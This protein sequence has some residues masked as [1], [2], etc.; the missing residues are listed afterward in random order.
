MTKTAAKAI[1]SAKILRGSR[2]AVDVL[3]ALALIGVLAPQDRPG[4]AE[5]FTS[6][7]ERDQRPNVRVEVQAPLAWW[8]TGLGDHGIRVEV[9]EQLFGSLDVPYVDLD[10]QRPAPVPAA[11]HTVD[12]GLSARVRALGP[13]PPKVAASVGDGPAAP[14]DVWA[15]RREPGRWVTVY[16]HEIR[17]RERPYAHTEFLTGEHEEMPSAAEITL[18]VQP[19]ADGRAPT[20]VHS[21]EKTSWVRRIAQGLDEPAADEPRP[22]DGSWVSAK[23]LRGLVGWHFK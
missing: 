14:G 23:D 12:G 11:K 16:V 18:R 9:F 2:T 8:D 6:Y 10:A 19:R 21:L 3:E 20:W 7:R 17:E 5:R 15:I 13:K 22:G 4:M 1:T